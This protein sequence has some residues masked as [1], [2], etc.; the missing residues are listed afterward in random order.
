MH[1]VRYKDCMQWLIIFKEYTSNFF[2]HTF[3]NAQKFVPSRL[4]FSFCIH[5]LVFFALHV[6]S[7]HIS[8]VLL[9]GNVL[10][11]ISCMLHFA[12]PTNPRLLLFQFIN[13]RNNAVRKSTDAVV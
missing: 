13:K 10:I 6:P 4:P 11:H 3:K 12:Q 2:G 9:L 8:D 5:S 1:F 7:L